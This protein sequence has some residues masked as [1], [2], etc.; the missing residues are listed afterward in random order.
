MKK[1]VFSLFF[2]LLSFLPFFIY[3]QSSK[4]NLD[5]NSK[6][7]S[8]SPLQSMGSIKPQ[9][10]GAI[11]KIADATGCL[12]TPYGQYPAT[13]FTPSCTGAAELITGVG[14][15]GEYSLVNVTSGTAYTFL[16][17]TPT[18]FITIADSKGTIVL[19]VGT[20]SVT[21][22]PNFTGTVRFITHLDTE[23]HLNSTNIKR[24]VK[25][26]TLPPVEEPNYGCDQD[27]TGVF[28]LASSISKDIGYSVS[29]DFFVP[30][31]S[32]QYK[33]NG[34]SA[35]LF[36]GTGSDSDFSTFD[37]TLLKDSGSKTPGEVVNT[38]TGITASSI[39]LFP[40]QFGT[41]NV[42]KVKLDLGGYEL[43]VNASIDTRYW[44]AL[45][46]TSATG[47]NIFITEYNYNE[48]WKT[49]SAYQN[50]NGGAWTAITFNN[51]GDH[52]EGLWSID[53]ECT[54]A[55][56]NDAAGSSST[57]YPNPVKDYLTINAKQKIENVNIFSVAG[58]LVMSDVKLSNGQVNMSKLAPGVY[59]VRLSLD[60]GKIEKFKIIKK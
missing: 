4:P 38:W 23:C 50:T 39:E 59:I 36:P 32:Q 15:T 35:V 26:G 52:Y 2:L 28:S 40:I 16:V 27:Y 45:A 19:A 48:G 30:M 29:N 7:E 25:C 17:G 41:S 44:I 12:T 58:Q 56:V 22:T 10:I 54:L 57:Y 9:N 5:S 49:A 3:A 14:Y 55:G 1:T 13:A 31:E 46:A 11:G 43:P 42:Y 53:A 47:S 24:A 60:G 33:I 18:L 6:I 37:V 51:I 20:G 21:Y 34:I 8:Y